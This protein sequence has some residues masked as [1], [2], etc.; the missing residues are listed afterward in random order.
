MYPV[1]ILSWNLGEFMRTK[2]IQ[3]AE[4][5]ATSD[6]ALVARP[7]RGF[8]C[9]S[10]TEVDEMVET[11]IAAGGKHAME[12][13]ELGFTYGWSSYDLDGHH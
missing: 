8:A 4:A 13:Q 7:R 1:G 9:R 10:T 2:P 6:E 11:T 3:D 12:K 5:P